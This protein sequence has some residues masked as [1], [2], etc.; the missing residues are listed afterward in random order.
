MNHYSKKRAKQVREYNSLIVEYL[1]EN[2]DCGR[3][4]DPA[5][6]IHHKKGR[7]GEMLLNTKYW[8]PACIDCHSWIEAH[9][10]EAKEKGYSLN[11]LS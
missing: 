11:R 8:M 5:G 2:P 3:C 4:G 7:M 10:K 6:T 1:R 9:P